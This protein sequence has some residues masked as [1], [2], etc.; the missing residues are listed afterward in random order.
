MLAGNSDTKVGSSQFSMAG[1][2]HIEV[3]ESWVQQKRLPQ[4]PSLAHHTLAL[5]P[6]GALGRLWGPWAQPALEFLSG[7][8]QLSLMEKQGEASFCLLEHSYQNKRSWGK[9]KLLKPRQRWRKLCSL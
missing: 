3:E 9:V 5:Q 4:S 8:A 1:N 2:L 6:P 7:V